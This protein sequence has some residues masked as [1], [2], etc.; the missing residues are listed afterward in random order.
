MTNIIMEASAGLHKLQQ[1]DCP[2]LSEPI[3]VS[4]GSPPPQPPKPSKCIKGYDVEDWPTNP[5]YDSEEQAWKDTFMKGIE[6][7]HCLNHGSKPKP[8]PV[9][10]LPA[11]ITGVLP[12]PLG[13]TAAQAPTHARE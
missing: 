10:S 5:S 1:D 9:V 11:S 8:K 2:L 4:D 13:K 6:C 12:C 7:G 3:M